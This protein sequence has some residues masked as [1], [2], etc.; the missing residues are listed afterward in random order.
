MDFVG[1]HV[2]A[3]WGPKPSGFAHF[4]DLPTHSLN[5]W[6]LNIPKESFFGG[7]GVKARED[8]NVY[9]GIMSQIDMFKI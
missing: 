2:N 4:W 6:I 5:T 1:A 9:P 8:L 3:T 7:E